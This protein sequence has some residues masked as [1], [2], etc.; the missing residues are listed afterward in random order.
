MGGVKVDG[1]IK[2][3]LVK[4][5]ENPDREGLKETPMRVRRAYDYLLSGYKQDPKDVL[6]TKFTENY[7]EM[8][9]L[10]D[11][12]F[13]SLCEHH[14]LPFFGKCSIAY[15]PSDKIVGISKLARLVEC[16]SRRLQVQERL[17][18]QI[19]DALVKH[20]SPKGCGCIIEAS[21]MCMMM[22]GIQKQNS[23]MTTSALRG[24]LKTEVNAR[25]EFL[26]LMGK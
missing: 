13:Y 5:G 6:V 12:E 16:Y 7:D 9:V 4:V 26:K 25:Q 21:H 15:I 8:V 17:T 24:C 23:V 11:I 20:L 14:M 22:R 19:V 1:L 3:I 10:R 2:E 18:N